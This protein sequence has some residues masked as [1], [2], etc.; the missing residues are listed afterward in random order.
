V[1]VK[2]E[3]MVFWIVTLCSD[4]VGTTILEDLAASRHWCLITYYTGSQ[5]RRPQ[6]VLVILCSLY[7]ISYSAEKLYN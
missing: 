7:V 2:I 5:L 6:L 1:A 3:V 4:M